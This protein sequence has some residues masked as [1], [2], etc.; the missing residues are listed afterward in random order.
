LAVLALKA[1]EP[2]LAD[3]AE[4]EEVELLLFL[5]PTEIARKAN[6]QT[7]GKINFLRSMKVVFHYRIMLTICTNATEAKLLWQRKTES[8][9]DP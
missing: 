3:I 9:Y 7:V 5:Q 1:V 2:K 4:V 8:T 6:A